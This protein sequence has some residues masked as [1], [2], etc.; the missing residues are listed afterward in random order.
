MFTLHITYEKI[1]YIF[2]RGTFLIGLEL[3]TD[4]NF[5]QN[6]TKWQIKKVSFVLLI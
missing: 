6:K 3:K 2:H 5:L 4:Q 1:F